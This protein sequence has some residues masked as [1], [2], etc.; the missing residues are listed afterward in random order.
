MRQPVKQIAYKY[1][2]NF[3]K[4]EFFLPN[5]VHQLTLSL[6]CNRWKIQDSGDFQDDINSIRCSANGRSKANDV[7]LL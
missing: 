2:I 7:S 3:A 1:C 6:H 5:I 4:T